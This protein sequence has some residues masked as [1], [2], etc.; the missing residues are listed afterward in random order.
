MRYI[1][2][3]PTA[4]GFSLTSSYE[5]LSC[6]VTLIVWHA[7]WLVRELIRGT[8]TD[9]R[10]TQSLANQFL[11][12]RFQKFIVRLAY[13]TL[14]RHRPSHPLQNVLWRLKEGHI[15]SKLTCRW[16]KG[17][18]S[19]TLLMLQHQVRCI[20][21]TVEISGFLDYSYTKRGNTV[22]IGGPWE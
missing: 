10:T 4:P 16:K 1:Y 8:I 14:L 3:R 15:R 11:L 21:V 7:K 13:A 12:Q 2:K 19:H 22:P 6:S 5:S 20:V 17:L 9:P 18:N